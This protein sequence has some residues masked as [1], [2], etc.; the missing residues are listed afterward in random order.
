MIKKE[1]FK[2]EL[3]DKAP[4]KEQLFQDVVLLFVL[5]GKLEAGVENKV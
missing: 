2:T 1:W 4:E 3:H 5:E